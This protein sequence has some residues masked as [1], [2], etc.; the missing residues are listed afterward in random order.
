[1]LA[2]KRALE[3]RHP[4]HETRNARPSVLD[5]KPVAV[6]RRAWRVMPLRSRMRCHR[7]ALQ[8]SCRLV[9]Y[10]C[11]NSEEVSDC[12]NN[13]KCGLRLSVREFANHGGRAVGTKRR[14]DR[15]VPA[16]PPVA[17][18]FSLA[19]CRGVRTVRVG[20]ARTSLKSCYYT[21]C[22]SVINSLVLLPPLLHIGYTIL[23]KLPQKKSRHGALAP[24]PL[25]GPK[26]RARE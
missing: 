22:G 25:K 14:S 18:S 1:M 20:G 26:F 12:K 10:W 8:T 2:R 4:L 23:P 19:T 13:V 17:P 6:P 24:Q 11:N 7:S 9:P 21:V 16:R 3:R 15:T 5:E